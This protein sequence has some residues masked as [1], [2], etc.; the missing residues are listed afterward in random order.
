MLYT[1]LETYLV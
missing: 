1:V